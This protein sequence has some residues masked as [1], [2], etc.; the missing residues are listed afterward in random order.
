MRKALFFCVVPLCL[1]LSDAVV[2]A[3]WSI[4]PSVS[5]RE[6]YNDNIRFTASPHPGVWQS[7]LSPGLRMSSK[8]EV[9]EVSGLAQL[10]IIQFAGDPQVKNRNDQVF[11]LLTRFQSERNTWAI[12]ASYKQ[13]S[14]AD[15][16]N[17][18][19]VAQSFTQR[20]SLS[21]SPSWTRTLTERSSLTLNYSYQEMKYD[22]HTNNLNEYTSQ[23][24]GGTL[25]YQLS[26]RDQVSL[27]VNHLVVEYSPISNLLANGTILSIA[28]PILSLGSG[29]DILV[30]ESGTSNVQAGVT[31]QFSETL[32]G[33][34]SLGRRSTVSNV[35][36]ACT[37]CFTG[38]GVPI[39]TF[40]NETSTSGYSFSATLEKTFDAARVSGF[41]SRDANASGSGL[42]ETDKFG[43]SLSRSLTEKL[44]GSFD[45]TA[46]RTKYIDATAPGSRYYTFE[47]K[48]NW[49]LTEWWTLDAGYRYARSESDAVTNATTANLVY[50][51][52]AYNWPKMAI[53]R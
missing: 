3:E 24:V 48:L 5:L 6:E 10:N 2:A 11:S 22:A 13:D 45:A 52:L 53:S 20:S 32:R 4:E 27:S 15:E 17:T 7:R 43:V 12:N 14:T 51:N 26:E 42:V 41:A 34:L 37:S 21:L 18:T 44:T 28:P 40:T 38:G 47:P 36:H 46:Y 19:G 1:A 25:Q 8:T 50:L 30:N 39:N 29:T 49:R 31:R 9:A 16:R 33:S 35:S 23:Q